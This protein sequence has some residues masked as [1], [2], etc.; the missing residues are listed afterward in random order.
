MTS[1]QQVSPPKPCIRLSSPPIRATCTAHLILDVT[2][3]TI[4][5]EQYR[6]LISSLCGFLHSPVTSSLLDPNTFFCTLLSNTLSLRSSLSVSD[7]VSHP[8]KTTL[9]TPIRKVGPSPQRQ[10][11]KSGLQMRTVCVCVCIYIYI[12]YLFNRSCID[13]RWQ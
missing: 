12:Y 6:S 1:L 3:R 11:P 2:T 10:T 4:L 5:G 8:Y 9:L 7:Q 13:A